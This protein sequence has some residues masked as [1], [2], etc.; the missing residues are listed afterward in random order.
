MAMGLNL[1]YTKT[2]VFSSSFAC[3]ALK[4]LLVAP[5]HNL[6]NSADVCKFLFVF[7]LQTVSLTLCE[8]F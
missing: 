6:R 3:C 2:L 8:T 4:S 7:K 1:V 5:F